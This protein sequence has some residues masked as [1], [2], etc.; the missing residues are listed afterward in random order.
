MT[1]EHGTPTTQNTENVSQSP[2]TNGNTQ[3]NFEKHIIKCLNHQIK[4]SVPK[5]LFNNE[6]FTLLHLNN[7]Q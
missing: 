5:Y 6:M 4:H 1:F 2:F 7:K 3:R